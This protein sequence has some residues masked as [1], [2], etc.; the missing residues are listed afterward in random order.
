[1]RAEVMTLAETARE[2][3]RLANLSDSD[4]NEVLDTL[5]QD[6]LNN[7]SIIATAIREVE[8]HF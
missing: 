5:E 3:F 6:V 1:M 8:R 2:A 4:F 7:Y